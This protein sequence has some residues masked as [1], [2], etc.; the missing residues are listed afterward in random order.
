VERLLTVPRV[1]GAAPIV[2]GKASSSRRGGEAFIEVKGVIPEQERTV[3]QI[4]RAM[5]RAARR[6]NTPEE[7]PGHPARQGSGRAAAV[8]RS[9]T[10]PR[11]HDPKAHADA[12]RADVCPRRFKVAGTFSLGLLEYDS[13]YAF[14]RWTSPSDLGK[15]QPDFIE[16]RVDDMFA[17]SRSPI[18][19]RRVGADYIAQDWADL[20]GAVLGVV[21]REDGDLDHDWADRDGRGAQHRRVTRACS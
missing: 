7:T 13:G 12:L 6:S 16:L 14:V 15:E 3:T 19:S 1:V 20:N 4:E 5:I 8:Y 2:Q 10:G 17:A 9:A 21:A 18:E 11:L